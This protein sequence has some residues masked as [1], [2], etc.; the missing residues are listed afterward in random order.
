MPTYT[1]DEYDLPDAFPSYWE[2]ST[3]DTGFTTAGNGPPAI[4]G[5]QLVFDTFRGWRDDVITFTDNAVD[6]YLLKNWGVQFRI[7]EQDMGPQ[8]IFVVTLADHSDLTPENP[9][10]YM[11]FRF[12]GSSGLLIEWSGTPG[13][14][15]SL[16]TTLTRDPAKP[17]YRMWQQLGY[18]RFER[19]ADGVTWEDLSI[20]YLSSTGYLNMETLFVQGT[21]SSSNAGAVGT[22]NHGSLNLGQFHI[23]QMGPWWGDGTDPTDPPVINYRVFDGSVW[24]PAPRRILTSGGVWAPAD[25]RILT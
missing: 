17:Y 5:G 10:H 18:P 19:S 4:I 25:Y 15:S 11:R 7:D 16:S 14:G 12:V 22:T 13:S 20:A 3:T 8:H 2:V 9:A 24:N 23:A 6:P 21:F 1:L